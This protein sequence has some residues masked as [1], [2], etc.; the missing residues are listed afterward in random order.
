MKSPRNAAAPDVPEASGATMS[1]THQTHVHCMAY[2]EVNALTAWGNLL[3]LP[4]GEKFPPP[5]GY[6]G[7]HGR[8][9]T[10]AERSQW[11]GHAGNFALRLPDGVMAIDVD[12][13]GPKTGAATL[14]AK[15]AELGALPPTVTSTRRDPATGSS[16]RYYR[17]PGGK[18]ASVVGPSVE[19]LQRGH[20]YAVV[21]PSVVDGDTYRWYAAD[22]TALDAPPSLEQLAELPPA[23]VAFLQAGASSSLGP[24]A[25]EA[26]RDGLLATLAA[27]GRTPCPEV[28]EA[29]CHS[30]E[31]LQ[32][33]GE[34]GR[35]DAATGGALA[36]VAKLAAGHA[37]GAWA[38]SELRAS[39][40]EAVG[41]D[42]A[43]AG[44]FDRMVTSAASKLAT[45]QGPGH[46]PCDL[47]TQLTTPPVLTDAT[48]D[49]LGG[50]TPLDLTAYANG[51][52]Q[53]EPATM[54]KRADGAGL[55]YP[56]KTHAFNG[57]P[58]SGKSMLAQWAVAEELR[59]GRHVLVLDYES[60]A[61]SYVERVR[62]MGVA[63]EVITERLA[64]VNPPDDPATSPHAR[65]RLVALVESRTFSLAVVDGLT[66]AL[67]LMGGSSNSGDDVT[68][69][70][71]AV[72]RLLADHGPA[73]VVV[74]HVTKDTESRGR[75]AI[76]SQSKLAA[77]T[78]AAYLV[79][80]AKP[81]GRGAVGELV[82]KV[83]KDRPGY[84]RGMAGRW[85]ARTR[86]QEAAR[87]LVDG[88]MPGRIHVTV[89][90]PSVD[91]DDDGQFRPSGYMERV[92]RALE[93]AS[94]SL[95]FNK[96]AEA[97]E[98]KRSVVQAAV[99]ALVDEGYVERKDG[100][101][102]SKLHTS[103]KP[104]READDP[105]RAAASSAF[106]EAVRA[107]FPSFAGGNQS[108]PELSVQRP[109]TGSGLRD[110][111]P[112]TSRDQFPGTSGNQSG[113]SDQDRES[114]EA[115]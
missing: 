8:D 112:G 89:N 72:P 2:A 63:P 19:V 38:L 80:V 59:A 101:R 45:P 113:T 22:G 60:D 102:N 82:L 62:A 30:Q 3:P 77:L 68:R 5:S 99:T 115:K 49:T 91:T 78:G 14:A 16:H 20:R 15:E 28:S 111:E 76:G 96:I 103:V 106:A 53:P 33:V 51:T 18:L 73:V 93:D 105:K 31:R 10:D 29:V 114:E 66:E 64:Y 12:N 98:G 26:V 36:V 40:D 81:L 17:Y 50:W 21:W 43:R 79:D 46:D 67:A 41:H 61:A 84:V 47:F 92:S 97:V 42:P 6:T 88:T 110:R 48:P 104:Y 108:A 74:D 54:L 100:P 107:S 1:G 65:A 9:V 4:A 83:A 55:L 35:H 44:E 70:Q 56:G 57:E 34:G 32:A 52:H 39:W 90:A 71:Q 13:Y 27:D 69:W 95:T 37:G 87:V 25:P 75:F 94:E 85:S 58:E 86:L 109:V 24:A 11:A 7:E 23:W